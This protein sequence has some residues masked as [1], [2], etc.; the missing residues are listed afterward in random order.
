MFCTVTKKLR[1][2]DFSC[3]LSD[4]NDDYSMSNI[5]IS[6]QMRSV[7]FDTLK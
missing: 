1:S 6:E 4:F 7:K 5:L 2:F 3:F